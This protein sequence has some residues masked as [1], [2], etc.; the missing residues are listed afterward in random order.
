MRLDST[1]KSFISV[2]IP[3]YNCEAHIE[4]AVVSILN[5][6]FENFEIICVDDCS[7]DKSLEKIE[8]IRN[9][10]NRI[11]LFKNNTN[12]GIARTLNICIE[13]VD[14]CAKYIVR[15]DAD[16]VSL[17]TRLQEQWDYMESNPDVDISGA[18]VETFGERKEKKI[19]RY[20]ENHCDIISHFSKYNCIWHPTVIAKA[21]FF[22]ENDLRYDPMYKAEDYELWAR[23][24]VKY[25]AKFG[26]I[27]KVLLNYRTHSKQ[28]TVEN[29]DAFELE[30]ITDMFFEEKLDHFESQ[31]DKQNSLQ[32]FRQTNN[33][34]IVMATDN[35]YAKYLSVATQSILQNSSELNNYD[36]VVLDGGVDAAVKNLLLSQ[37]EEFE[38]FSLRFVSM[39]DYIDLIG[40]ELFYESDHISVASYYRLF[41][42]NVM[43]CYEKCLYLDLDVILNDDVANLYSYDLE[44]KVMGVCEDIGTLIARN[45]S[46]DFDL[47]LKGE[48]DLTEHDRYFN[49]GVLSISVPDFKRYQRDFFVLLKKLK[50]PRCHD[51]DILN[52]VLRGQVKYIDAKWNYMWNVLNLANYSCGFYLCEKEIK[53]LRE[54]RENNSYCLVHYADRV[55][56]WFNSKFPEASLFWD[57]ARETPYYFE[58][59]KGLIKKSI[60]KNKGS[61]LGLRFI[62]LFVPVRKARR[63]IRALIK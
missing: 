13:K 60:L 58:L 42:S 50:V 33:V 26:N 40:G 37:I 55:K 30:E 15:M 53:Y 47:Y 17:R 35:N 46:E 38:N 39:D 8:N 9:I 43:A 16:D 4:E 29:L 34:P 63:K 7:S 2:I 22:R 10:D 45:Q 36:I 51:Q 21:G 48:L 1:K 14:L 31:I 49:A 52:S 57:Y 27:Q 20:P 25:G 12:L 11:K 19:R 54:L 18:W 3:V 61:K 41:I 59:R 32:P 24:Y 62:S 44:G 56:P 23:S 28:L 6:T 5:Q